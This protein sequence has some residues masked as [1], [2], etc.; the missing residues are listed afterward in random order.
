MNTSTSRSRVALASLLLASCSVHSD[1]AQ[2]QVSDNNS[3]DDQRYTFS[4]LFEP[5]SAL[6]PRGGDTPGPDIHL[7]PNTHTGWLALKEKGISEFERD[8]RAILAMQGPYRVSFDFLEVEKYDPNADPTKPYQS[9]STEFVYLL[10]DA[11]EFISLQ[12]ILVA[13]ER[14]EDG[15]AGTA[16]VVK[17]WRQDWSYQDKDLLSF[18]GHGT[19]AHDKITDDHA[20]GKWSQAVYQVDDSPRY[21]GIGKWM[22]T[23]DFST[24]TSENTWR[25]LPRR[26]Y[27]VRDD[28]H[29][30][31]AINVHT[32]LPNGWSHAQNNLKVVLS[33]AG[34][35]DHILAREYGFNR[36]EL[37]E[38][39]DFSPGDAYWEKTRAYWKEIRDHWSDVLAQERFTIES[40]VDN[41][42]LWKR[43][44]DLAKNGGEM[45]Q[46]A[47]SS[48]LDEIIAMHI[49][50]ESA[51]EDSY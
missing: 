44:F 35:V 15:S 39:F 1:S 51:G 16:H 26:E 18:K 47:R 21:E 9:W 11:G 40:K 41:V 7:D 38:D 43:L 23:D 32:I 8:R 3:S 6:E 19:W 12:H 25:P 30:L 36:Y 20:R 5:E 14:N 27:T 17:H 10:E 31:D 42:N 24:W 45:S 4:Y 48:K 22:H 37:I 2:E 13:R 28:Y 49:K 34:K 50:N 46:A 33:G 29:V